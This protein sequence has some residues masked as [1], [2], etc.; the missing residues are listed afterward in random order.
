V[1][2]Y[3]N[4]KIEKFL[5]LIIRRRDDLKENERSAAMRMIEGLGEVW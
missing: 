3:F 2:R 5:E 4:W 1:E